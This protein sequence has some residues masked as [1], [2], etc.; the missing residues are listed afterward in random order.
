MRLEA[1]FLFPQVLGQTQVVN[2][3]ITGA[4]WFT[5]ATR[6]VL[7]HTHGRNWAVSVAGWALKSESVKMRLIMET[8]YR[9]RENPPRMAVNESI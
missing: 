3:A 7:G 4:G 5:G 6:Q 1:A 2:W 9:V 8:V